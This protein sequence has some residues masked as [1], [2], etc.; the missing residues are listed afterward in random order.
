MCQVKKRENETSS[1]DSQASITSSDPNIVIDWPTRLRIAIGAAKGL[2]Y[3]HHDCC[4]PIIHRD[5]KSSNILLDIEFNA[6]I[7]DFG[8]AKMSVKTGEPY[9]A[10]IV[11]GSFGY[12]A[13]GNNLLM[14]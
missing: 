11:A 2:S 3:L 5:V 1:T 12:I 6:K 9:T 10:S 7:A 4:F 13:P 14:A 8:L